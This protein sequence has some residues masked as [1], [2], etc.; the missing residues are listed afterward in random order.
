M[1]YPRTTLTLIALLC[2]LSASHRMN[3]DSAEFKRQALFKDILKTSERLNGASNGSQPFNPSE[4]LHDAQ[5]L[6]QLSRLPWPLFKEMQQTEKSRA[7]AEIWSMQHDFQQ[8]ALDFQQQADHVLSAAHTG[9]QNTLHTAV[10]SLQESCNSC[11][12]QFR[13]N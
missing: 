13:A 4:V 9:Q 10:K 7:N 6:Q 1:Q 5:A 2:T 11:H 12:K 3:P 8:R